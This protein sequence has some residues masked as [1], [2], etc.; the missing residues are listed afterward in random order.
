MLLVD[1][2]WFAWL[3][4]AFVLRGGIKMYWRCRGL[5]ELF[6]HGGAYG[7]AT[8]GRRSNNYNEGGPSVLVVKYF[9]GK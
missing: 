2:A 1:V 9:L 3:G 4:S 5:K 8:E 6:V 7:A